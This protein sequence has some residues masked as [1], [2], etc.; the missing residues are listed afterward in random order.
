MSWLTLYPWIKAIHL[1]FAIAWM[2]GLLMYPRLKI[3]QLNDEPGGKLFTVMQSAS[4]RLRKIILTPGLLITWAL[5]LLL[6]FVSPMEP[7]SQGWFHV[8]LL[9]L[10]VI[11]AFHGIFISTGKKIDAGNSGV[12]EKRLRLLNEVPFVAMIVVV[13]MVIVQPSF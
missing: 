6:M 8:K 11:T 1:I 7:L 12:S 13:I 4:N 2:A 9:F 5:G 10:L 3:Y